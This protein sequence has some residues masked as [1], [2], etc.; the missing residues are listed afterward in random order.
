MKSQQ[1]VSQFEYKIRQ[2]R[3]DLEDIVPF[4]ISISAVISITY[5]SFEI[6][7]DAAL[8]HDGFCFTYYNIF[9][10]ATREELGTASISLETIYDVPVCCDVHLQC[11]LGMVQVSFERLDL[12]PDQGGLR[13]EQTST[14]WRVYC[15][16]RMVIISNASLARLFFINSAFTQF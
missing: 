11:P 14:V 12:H 10:N 7:Y 16:E 8:R 15:I 9:D 3:Q 1:K 4:F 2:I 6:I 5:C 13:L